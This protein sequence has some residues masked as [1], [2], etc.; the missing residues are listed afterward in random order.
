MHVTDNATP[1]PLENLLAAVENAINDASWWPEGDIGTP[2]MVI[3]TQAIT[4]LRD[5]YHRFIDPE[6]FS[7]V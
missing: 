5:A 3:S 2:E 1:S 4:D 7:D 6:C